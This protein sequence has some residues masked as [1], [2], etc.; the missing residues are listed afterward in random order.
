MD[1]LINKHS[2]LNKRN[3]IFLRDAKKIRKKLSNLIK[4]PIFLKIKNR[5]LNILYINDTHHEEKSFKV[6]GASA[7][8]LN[9]YKKIKKK[10]TIVLAST[11]NFACAMANICKKNKIGCVVFVTN[12]IDKNKLEKLINLKAKV[13]FSKNYEVAKIKA[14]NFSKKNNFFF[15]NGCNK[16]IFL[17]NSS[18]FLDAIDE[19][20]KKDKKIT[21]KK[22]LAI[23]PV[24][25]GSLAAPSSIILKNTLLNIDIACVEPFNF[26]KSQK[27]LNSKISLNLKNTV[28]DGTAIR[29]LPEVSKKIIF[30]NCKY[31]FSFKEKEIINSMKYIFQKFKIISEGS[32]ALS[33]A[34]ILN[35][36][37][38][39]KNYEYV[40]VPICGGNIDK[41]KL[42]GYINKSQNK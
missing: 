3:L 12:N 22:V 20:K 38:F 4:K 32:G 15:S 42:L 18:M 31:F 36:P 14:K 37:K 23:L 39:V 19:L 6:R 13:F 33:N 21:K 41:I 24:G 7:E 9:N 25:N 40:I 34:L 8:I 11:G 1:Y 2:N 28:A 35:Y 17:G 30:Q 27:I 29:K 10:N 5:D 26:K 16:N